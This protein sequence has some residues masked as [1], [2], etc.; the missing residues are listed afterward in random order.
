MH[1][2]NTTCNK[3][4]LVPLD[5]DKSE[6]ATLPISSKILPKEET[7]CLKDIIPQVQRK[8]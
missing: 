3:W 1:Y 8:I 5:L 7:F 6:S 2:S 4:R